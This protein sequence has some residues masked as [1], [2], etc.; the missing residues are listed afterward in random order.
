MDSGGDEKGKREPAVVRRKKTP[1]KQARGG[2][3]RGSEAQAQGPAISRT[4]RERG[5]RAVWLLCGGA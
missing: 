3:E 4:E 5:E 2:S 1:D